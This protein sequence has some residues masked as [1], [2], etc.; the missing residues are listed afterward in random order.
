MPGFNPPKEDTLQ[1]Q[2]ARLKQNQEE[3]TRTEQLALY[4]T[5]YAR[6]E[7]VCRN[8]FEVLLERVPHPV[9]NIRLG[10]QSAAK[11]AVIRNAADVLMRYHG[12]IQEQLLKDNPAYFD[13]FT[14]SVAKLL[15]KVMVVNH[16][17]GRNLEKNPTFRKFLELQNRAAVELQNKAIV[18]LAERVNTL[19]LGKE[20]SDEQILLND[21]ARFL[22][23]QTALSL[24]QEDVR[25]TLNDFLHRMNEDQLT[26][27]QEPVDA[28]EKAFKLTGAFKDR[29]PGIQ[30]DLDTAAE[31]QNKKFAPDIDKQSKDVEKEWNKL[32][33]D[34]DKQSKE[35]EKDI[36][37]DSKGVEEEIDKQ[38]REFQLPQLRPDE[39]HTKTADES[40]ELRNDRYTNLMGL[41][42]SAFS[43]LMVPVYT[44]LGNA[45]G[46]LEGMRAK[47]PTSMENFDSWN[48][49]K[50]KSEGVYG[51]FPHTFS[52]HKDRILQQS[53]PSCSPTPYDTKPHPPDGGLSA[54]G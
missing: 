19:A 25:N 38:N 39:E 52:K 51:V 54:A 41:I 5:Q 24:R 42:S 35:M 26:Q 31:E 43:S 45:L 47:Q 1:W 9:S 50:E 53:T 46:L 2:N 15:I 16:Y 44:N 7:T 14:H 37:K 20:F 21:F 17:V 49:D 4:Q 32:E 18:N 33:R 29:L 30:K 6:C 3:Q 28:L 48:A 8:L 36:E 12:P 10:E 34:I 27:L 11:E 40:T 22:E 23:N 13:F